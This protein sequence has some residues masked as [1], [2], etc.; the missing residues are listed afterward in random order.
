MG[1]RLEPITEE[2]YEAWYSA[3][4]KEYAAAH[5]RTGQMSPEE[6]EAMAR[7]EHGEL[8]PDGPRSPNQYLYQIADSDS[9]TVVGIIWFAKR[10]DGAPQ[11]FVYALEV[12][13]DH[14]R[15]GYARAAML[16]LEDEVRR[17]GLARVGLHV[18]GDNVPA[19]RLY[20]SLGYAT[21]N[22]LMKKDLEGPDGS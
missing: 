5:A 1:A 10:G 22:V 12:F 15:R 3:S 14:R 7:R 9:G 2:V 8:L 6:A 4:V 20:E 17:L 19:I 11:A 16:A 13:P 21:T 18:F